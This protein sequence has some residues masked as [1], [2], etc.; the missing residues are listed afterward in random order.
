MSLAL[1]DVDVGSIPDLV[2]PIEAWRVW[3]VSVR[4]SGAYPI[5][6]FIPAP[7]VMQRWLRRRAYADEIRFALEEYR[8]PVDLVAPTALATY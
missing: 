6:L 5:E 8:V 1:S 3:R 4:Q 2:E 7:P